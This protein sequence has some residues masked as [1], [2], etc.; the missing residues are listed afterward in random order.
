[1]RVFFETLRN[2][3]DNPV[4]ALN[5]RK[6]NAKESGKGR[7]QSNEPTNDIAFNH[8]GNAKALYDRQQILKCFTAEDSFHFL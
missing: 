8:A 4:R 2:V 7:Q 3:V 1:M 5:A 6:T